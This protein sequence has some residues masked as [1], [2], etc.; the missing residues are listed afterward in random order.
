MVAYRSAYDCEPAYF[1]IEQS[2]LERKL[3]ASV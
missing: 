1:E 3:I 2:N